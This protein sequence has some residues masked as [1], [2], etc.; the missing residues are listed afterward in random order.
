MKFPQTHLDCAFLLLCSSFSDLLLQLAFATTSFCHQSTCIH[1][2]LV[3]ITPAPITTPHCIHSMRQWIDRT[4]AI[5]IS[6]VTSTQGW[7]P[8]HTLPFGCCCGLNS[9][10][11]ATQIH[12]LNSEHPVWLYCV[13]KYNSKE[14]ALVQHDYEGISWTSKT[15]GLIRGRQRP[16]RGHVLREGRVSI[17]RSLQVGKILNLT[18]WH[19]TSDFLLTKPRE[20]NILLCNRGGCAILLHHSE[21]TTWM[22]RKQSQNVTFCIVTLV[23]WFNQ[24]SLL[25]TMRQ[26]RVLA[27]PCLSQASLNSH[28]EDDLDAAIQTLQK[29]WPFWLVL[30]H[31][32]LLISLVAVPS[33]DSLSRH[34]YSYKQEGMNTQGFCVLVNSSLVTRLRREKNL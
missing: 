26:E 1:L 32:T 15:A 16:S 23:A 12:T 13:W 4:S 3:P 29:T 18:G 19:L 7:N 17:R 20:G 8:A 10:P 31:F 27:W 28:H 14:M 33:D 11:S 9:V 24:A 5:T 22:P 34:C 21:L 6:P 25:F 30:F 2:S